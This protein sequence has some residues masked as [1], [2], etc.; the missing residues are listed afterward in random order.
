[1]EIAV[2]K[3][4]IYK[5]AGSDEIPTEVIQAG[6]QILRSEFHKLGSEEAVYYC[7]TLQEM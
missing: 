6:G 7:A 4:E 2:C 1:V 3:V 5:T